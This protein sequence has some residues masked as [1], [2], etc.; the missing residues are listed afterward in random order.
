RAPTWNARDVVVERARRAGAPW[1]LV[2]PCPSLDALAM[3]PLETVSRA[4][5]RAGW[6]AVEVVDRRKEA[7]GLGLYSER[8]VRLLREDGRVVCVLNRKGR[9]RLLACANCG[10][11][12]R[13]ERCDAAV[14]QAED[15]TLRCGRCGAERPLVCLAC[16]ATR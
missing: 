6:P 4:E 5:E 15:A 1:L 7:P 16:G 14:E 2:S 12:A 13:C 8:L 3:G 10:D 11:L 9:A